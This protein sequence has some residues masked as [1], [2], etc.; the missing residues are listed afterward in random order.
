MPEKVKKYDRIVFTPET[1]RQAVS[2]L[3]SALQGESE[4]RTQRLM[5]ELPGGEKWRHD[6]EEEFFADYRKG[7][8][9]A[10]FRQSYEGKGSGA[11]IELWVSST[12]SEITVSMTD[13]ADIEAVFNIFEANVEACRVP[14]QP[15]EEFGIP[16][17]WI[18]ETLNQIE[19]HSPIVT[20]KL[21]LALQKLDSEDVEEWQSAT[22]LVRDAWIELTQ[23]LCK[24]R[25]VEVSD[26]SPDSVIDGLRKLGLD[27]AD[28]RTFNL[29]RASFGLYAKHH[30]RDIEHDTAVACVISTVVSMKTVLKE[31]L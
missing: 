1:I 29:A 21:R 13:R 18:A 8:K 19:T 5:T 26:I 14:K 16:P 31:I 30:K 22:M 17:D 23:W 28:E 2:A 6:T 4:K 9:T 27:K 10:R 7:C 11:L 25:G 15:E 3:K 24:A 20:R 12:N